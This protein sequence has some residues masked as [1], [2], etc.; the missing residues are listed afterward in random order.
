MVKLLFTMMDNFPTIQ[1]QLQVFG[2]SDKE[3]DVYLALFRQP[4]Q[5]VVTLAQIVN[6]PRPTLYRLLA[7]LGEQGLVENTVDHKT[8]YYSVTPAESLKS[9]IIASKKHTQELESAF[10]NLEPLLALPQHQEQ[11]NTALTFYRGKNG[12]KSMEW[13]LTEE[14]NSE[15]CMFGADIWW[16][17]LGQDFAE[18]IRRER[19]KSNIRRREILNSEKITDP[20]EKWTTV[21][22]Y[23]KIYSAR[24]ISQDILPID[25]EMMITSSSVYIYSLNESELVGI[26][27]TNSAYAST[28][29]ALF[30]MA[31]RVAKE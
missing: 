16:K 12:I 6:V 3:I 11:F 21:S 8:T 25:N 9:K 7:S 13:Q 18:E 24:Y 10:A 17:Y 14:K 23:L 4:W 15:I 28:M 19:V 22:A 31:W 30:E 1:Q 20:N 2:L 29:R 27:I 26:R 5:T